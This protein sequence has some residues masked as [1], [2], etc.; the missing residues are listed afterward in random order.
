MKH[1]DD[2]KSK[3]NRRAGEKSAND[4]PFTIIGAGAKRAPQGA[5]PPPSKRGQASSPA[6]KTANRSVFRELATRRTGD[7]GAKPNSA[8]V[9]ERPIT[10]ADEREAAALRRARILRLWPRLFR[11]GVYRFHARFALWQILAFYVGI[12]AVASMV[13]CVYALM[14]PAPRADIV[15]VSRPPESATTLLN[16]VVTALR[17]KDNEAAG[18]AVARLSEA[19]PDDARSLIA[20]GAYLS[21]LGK[22]EEARAALRRALELS[23]DNPSAT[24]SLAELEFSSGRYDQA[25]EYYNRLPTE[26]ANAA[27]VSFRLYICYEKTGRTEEAQ[28]LIRAR[29]FRSQS[30]EDFFIRAADASKRGDEAEAQRLV[31]SAELL[32]GDTA[33][34]YRVSL[35]KIGW[36]KSK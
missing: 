23:P 3:P 25:I 15:K 16:A 24:M 7:S 1:K 35:E 17:D 21:T 13:V 22:N 27:L 11:R 8:T 18:K 29:T 20:S 2:S 19:Y 33:K 12:P 5:E 30:A 26:T 31:S 10:E 34:A 9:G 36:L 6:K 4:A 14:M 28:A 32:F